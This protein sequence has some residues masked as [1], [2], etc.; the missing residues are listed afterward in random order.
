MRSEGFVLSVCASC[1]TLHVREK[2]GGIVVKDL[3]HILRE[4]AINALN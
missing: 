1:Q 3:K 2:L 4:I